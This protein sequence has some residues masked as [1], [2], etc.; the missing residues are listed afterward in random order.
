ML[1]SLGIIGLLG[2]LAVPCMG[3]AQ[4]TDLV[5]RTAA[6]SEQAPQKSNRLPASLAHTPGNLTVGVLDDGSVGT[7]N[8]A[9]SGPGVLWRGAQGIFVGG[10]IFG[11]AERA[12]V[13]GLMG[14]F[15]NPPPAIN[16]DLIT[17]ESTFANGF[18]TNSDFD[19]ISTARLNDAGAPTPY[20]VEILQQTYS[21]TGEEFCF[22]RYGFINTTALPLN[23]FYAGIF[24]DWD[25]FD[26]AANTGGYARE[27]HLVYNHSALPR[28]PPYHYGI[29]ALSGLSGMMTSSIIGRTPTART[30]AFAHL[31]IRDGNP[32][33]PA[34]DFRMWIGTGP[35]D[36]AP[37]DTAWATFAIVAGDDLT[38]IR[39]HARAARAKAVGLEWV[40][41]DPPS[42]SQDLAFTLQQV[43][44]GP[45]ITNVDWGSGA[46][47]GDY[48]N[49]GFLD[50]FVSS[51]STETNSSLFH[52]NGD[53]TF[54]R[55]EN[56]PVSTDVTRSYAGAWGDVNNDGYLDLYVSN[57]GDATTAP[58]LYENYL[59]LNGGP[60]NYAFTR[61]TEGGIV[62]DS[63]FTW[64][65]TLVDYDNDGD[66]DIHALAAQSST[67]E[68]F[69]ENDGT[70]GFTQPT[71]LPFINPGNGETGGVG[72]WIDFDGD[73]DQD[74]LVA[75]NTDIANELYQNMLAETGTL[76][77]TQVT[78]GELAV[79]RRGDSAT[80][81]G[82]YDNDG[83]QDLLVSILGGD[84]F[85][86]R[87]DI[88]EGGDFGLERVT[89]GLLANDATSSI[90]NSW[91][92]VDN[93]GDLDL[94]L[95]QVGRVSQLY[96][97]EGRGLFTS[98]SISQIGFAVANPTYE[99]S[100]AWGDYDNDGDLDLITVN[101]QSNDG[102]SPVPNFLFR[103]DN[104]TGNHWVN[105]LGFGTVSNTS[106]IGA[107]VR[108]K[109]TIG[110]QAYWQ[111]RTISGTP[112]GDRSHN[113]LRA[114]FGL[115]DATVID[116]LTVTWPSGITDVY[117]NVGVDAFY[118]AAEG[119][120]LRTGTTI[121]VRVKEE[122]PLPARFVL[123][124]NYPNP[125]NPTTT[126]RYD[127]S[128]IADVR[129]TIYNVLGQQVVRLLD[130]KSQA[131]GLYTAIWNGLDESGHRVASG[132]YIYRLEIGNDGQSRRMML[133]K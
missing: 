82:D 51:L 38:N 117:T 97:N 127:L 34:G 39:E 105:V 91:G 72:S 130:Q 4:H 92:D 101:S 86:Y 13:N 96:R 30:D 66:L 9:F 6:L 120:E 65:S 112:T 5:N 98:L 56:S 8:V 70:G 87:N 59:Y 14:T 35:L 107:V 102:N 131:P 129:L 17:L 54:T 124:Q 78:T 85:L 50:L 110:G 2:V 95:T 103:N 45:V 73:G 25:V 119:R 111:I 12:S 24:A 23:D 93:D 60:P 116:S 121:P 71:D 36:I 74:L 106:A 125:F 94:F 10:L 79:S 90:A 81:W 133:V 46:S 89:V 44:D 69:F 104:N 76:N 80:S 115:G 53:G 132:V 99:V 126:I 15:V 114:H 29:A 88:N 41:A 113:S 28:N 108:V 22:I 118:T 33:A 55:V 63:N 61:V 75:S 42:P 18:S 19:Q 37:G 48:D 27:E 57:G 123:H 100:A 40:A 83:D 109:A 58:P 122:L 1:R 64:S 3:Q 84:H 11:T 20:G 52:N 68:L 128:K 62:A 49:D 31:S 32:L 43:T 67:D 47:W 26:F 21:N 16:S 77:F 7:D